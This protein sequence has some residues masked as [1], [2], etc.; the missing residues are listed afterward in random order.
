MVSKILGTFGQ[1]IG[2]GYD[3]GCSFTTTVM[4]SSLSD[5]TRRKALRLVVNAFHGDAHNRLCQLRFHPLYITG[6]GVED[7]ETY[8][9]IFAAFNGLAPTTRHATRFHRHQAIDLFARHWD[10][11]KY[12]ELG[13]LTVFQRLPLLSISLRS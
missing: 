4:K 12:Q 2:L 10:E 6:F 3:I 7:I 13:K 1:R 5:E 9:R 11:Q 8:E